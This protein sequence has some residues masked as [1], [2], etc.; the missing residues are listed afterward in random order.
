MLSL[1]ELHSDDTLALLC[2][3]EPAQDYGVIS[4]LLLVLNDLRTG[5]FNEWKG[6]IRSG[7]D[8]RKKSI[9]ICHKAS[10]IKSH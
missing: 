6:P 5:G 10:M 1:L 9:Y 7:V 3:K 8:G 2:H 4:C